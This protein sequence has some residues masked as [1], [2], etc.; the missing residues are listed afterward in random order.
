MVG[1]VARDVDDALAAQSD[2]GGPFGVGPPDA[3]RE[4]AMRAVIREGG[5]SR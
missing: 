3:A 5:G 4:R 2:D 1:I